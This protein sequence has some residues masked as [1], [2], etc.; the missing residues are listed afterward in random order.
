MKP[1]KGILREARDDDQKIIAR[2]MVL[3]YI[4]LHEVPEVEA[5]VLHK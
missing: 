5:H 3:E 1:S 4:I 2:G